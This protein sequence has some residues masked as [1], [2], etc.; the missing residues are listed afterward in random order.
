MA[1][2]GKCDVE[3]GVVVV[4]LYVYQAAAC[5]FGGVGEMFHNVVCIKMDSTEKGPP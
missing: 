4:K 5:A 1:A 3:D 2:S